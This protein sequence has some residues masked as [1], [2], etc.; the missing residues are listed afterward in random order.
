[1]RYV[2]TV[3]LF[4]AALAA[5]GH[6]AEPAA[7][8]AAPSEDAIKAAKRDFE[9]LKATRDPAMQGKDALPK[10]SGPEFTSPVESM[11][12]LPK[13]KGKDA[14][15]EKQKK[16]ANWLLEAMEKKPD[17]R[18]SRRTEADRFVLEAERDRERERSGEDSELAALLKAAGKGDESARRNEAARDEKEKPRTEP[19][20]NPLNR[21]MSEW[22]TPQ[23]FAL[24]KPGLDAPRAGEVNASGAATAQV[25]NSE[26]V[27]PAT[28][29][30]ALGLIGGQKSF[31]PA[32]PQENPYLQT[33]NLPAPAATLTPPVLLPPPA[34]VASQPALAPPP[35]PIAPKSK[36]PD[37][38]KP[39]QDEKHFKQLKRF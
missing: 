12:R 24:L 34:P 26:F 30:A 28:P 7:Q 8:A 2:V 31:T 14:L 6:A 36:V 29:E 18:T 3:A 32:T 23:D 33:L 27:L 38:V 13:K 22:M 20:F 9:L 19:A 11:P 4:C 16:S 17:D 35:A 25:A 39:A 5:D 37:F 1:M 10:I 15:L 21:F